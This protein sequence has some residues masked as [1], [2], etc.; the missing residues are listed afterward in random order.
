MRLLFVAHRHSYAIVGVLL[1]GA[2]NSMGL[3]LARR[4]S[5]LYFFP[6]NARRSTICRG[7]A[8]R[9]VSTLLCFNK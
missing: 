4:G 8:R 3:T 9:E 1:S 5:C 2:F 7:V 6:L